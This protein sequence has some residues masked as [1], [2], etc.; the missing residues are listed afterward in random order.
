MSL[1]LKKK[2]CRITHINVREE[3]HGEESVTAVDIKVVDQ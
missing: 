1:E 3:K 2:P